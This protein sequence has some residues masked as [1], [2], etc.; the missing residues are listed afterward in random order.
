MFVRSTRFM[1]KSTPQKPFEVLT[2]LTLTLSLGARPNVVEPDQ[3]N[4]LAPAVFCDL[5][6][7]QNAKESRLASQ[8][9]CNIREADLLNRINLNFAFLHSISPAYVDAR[10]HPDSHAAS[11]FSA[12]YALAEPFREHHEESLRPWAGWS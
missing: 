1:H 5:E 9:G 2:R 11:D 4:I 3:I 12:A 8:F 6:Q 7:I 10:T